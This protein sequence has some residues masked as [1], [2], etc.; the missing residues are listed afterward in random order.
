MGLAD[1]QHVGSS[2]TRDRTR[3]PCIGRQILNHYAT[4]EAQVFKYI[5]MCVCI[6]VYNILVRAKIIKLLEQSICIHL[7]DLEF[8]NDF[9]EMT[10]KSQGTK[11]KVDKLDFIKIFK[12]LCFKGYYQENEKRGFPW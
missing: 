1:L 7:C 11:D 8:G 2:W 5:Y 10:L 3:V 12:C 9:L 4:R 6:Y